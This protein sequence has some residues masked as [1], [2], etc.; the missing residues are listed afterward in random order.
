MTTAA[1]FTLSPTLRRRV[2]ILAGLVFTLWATWKVSTEDAT[3]ATVSERS[4]P[5]QRRTGG[6]PS[7]ANTSTTAP[8]LALE[9]PMRTEQRQPVADLFSLA[10]PPAIAAPPVAVL[11]PPAAPA[12]KLKYVGRLDG[13]DNQ[14][15]FLADDKD[16][17]I[18][19]KV[20]QDLADG[21]QL[22]SMNSKL[23]VFR[24]IATGQEQTMSI[25]TLP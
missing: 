9:W 12:F 1:I 21:W 2:L 20:G 13:S 16:K 19:A 10:P 6:K 15:V 8:A 22:A 24:H 4:A 25:G 23:L 14:H 18:Q 5:A 17:V 7:S 3:D 11:A